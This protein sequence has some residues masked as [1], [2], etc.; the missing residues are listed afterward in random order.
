MIDPRVI[1]QA[2][3]QNN[4]SRALKWGIVHLCNLNGFGDMIKNKICNFLEFSHF[5]QFSIA[6]FTFFTNT[7]DL[8]NS[9]FYKTCCNSKRCTIPHFKAFDP[10]LTFS[11]TFD[12]RINHFGGMK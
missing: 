11:L 12:S 2:R 6:I 3:G 1:T 9:N 4:G 7:Q 5:L 10:F 8:K